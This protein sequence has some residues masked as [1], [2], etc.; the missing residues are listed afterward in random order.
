MLPILLFL[1]RK[2]GPELTSVSI[3]LHYI[4]GMPATAWLDKRYHVRTR[5]P[6]QRTPGRWSRMANLTAAP[7]GRPED[8][9]CLTSSPGDSGNQASL[10]HMEPL[11]MEELWKLWS[12][13]QMLSSSYWCRF[14]FL[15]LTSRTWQAW[16]LDSDRSRASLMSMWPVHKAPTSE[17]CQAW[18]NALLSPSFILNKFFIR[19]PH[20]HSTLDLANYLIFPRYK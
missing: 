1:L 15:S 8:Y 16:F 5:D 6:N 9:E 11:I 2:T 20:F 19:S 17:G 18:F 13:S 12:A 7:P 4:C 3:V 14:P 10:R